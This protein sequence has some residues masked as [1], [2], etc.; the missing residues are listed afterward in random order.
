MAA[1]G[2]FR[3]PGRSVAGVVAAFV[4]AVGLRAFVAAPFRVPSDSM[5]ETLLAGDHVWV[6]RVG[7]RVTGLRR[8]DV[9][10][11]AR[12]GRWHVKRVVAVGGDSVVW[13][14]GVLFVGGS[15][16]ALPGAVLGAWSVTCGGAPARR[17]VARESAARRLAGTCALTPD[18]R[19]VPD[20]ALAVP[21][22]AIYVLGDHRAAS[23]DSRGYGPVP[24]SRVVGRVAGVYL[25]LDPASGAAR[26][27]RVGRLR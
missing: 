7:P 24:V 22:G 5:A 4:V 8:G 23:E 6:D 14:S 15:A 1:R 17:F 27:E 11:F 13:R 20:T 26:Q 9:V 25:S 3:R 16:G 10:V 21:T 12:T 2:A 19:G 18:A